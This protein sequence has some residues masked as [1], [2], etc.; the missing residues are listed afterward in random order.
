M[1]GAQGE[2]RDLAEVRRRAQ[3]FSFLSAPADKLALLLVV[4]PLLLIVHSLEGNGLTDEVKQALLRD[5]AGRSANR[6]FA[7]SFVPSFVRSFFGSF[8]A[9]P[10]P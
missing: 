1:R 10:S 5:A 8:A 9:Q 3:A 6:S 4:H 7:G 2:R